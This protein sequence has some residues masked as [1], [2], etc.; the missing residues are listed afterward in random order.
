[1]STKKRTSLS[2]AKPHRHGLPLLPTSVIGSYSFPKWLDHVRVLGAN[3]TLTAEEVEEAHDNAVK[4][5]IKDQEMAG[6]DVITDGEIRRETMVYFFSKRIHGFD[7]EHAKM[8]PIGNLDPSIQMP[9]PVINDKVRWKQSLNMDVH[10]RFL[11]EHAVGRTKVCVTG[12]HM[13]A[14]RATDE[15]Y[16]DDK[17]LVF[18]LADILNKELR[19]LVAAGCDFIQ[20]DEPV[21]VGYP[22]DMAWLVESFN[23]LVEGVDAKIGLHVCYG[24]YQLK[25]LF[26]GQYAELFPAI[27]DANA[28]QICLEFAVSDGVGLELFRQYKTDKEVGVGV[29]DVKS[30]EVETPEA[31]AA[32]IRQALKYIPAE[33]MTI[34]PDCGMKFMPRA[35]AY[36]KLKAMVAGT[37]IVRRELGAE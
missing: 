28:D 34:V 1:M 26:R 21:W 16:R 36:G 19:G 17:A 24:N 3:G 33:R 8:H 32:R 6:V 5:A 37:R 20:I 18:D 13:L 14:K 22:Q 2:S 11:K 10:F 29:I 7:F 30:N 31:V 9:D 27:L 23:R 35:R 12:P 15:Y 4:S 25:K